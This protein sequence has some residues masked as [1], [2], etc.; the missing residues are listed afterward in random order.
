MNTSVCTRCQKGKIIKDTITNE[1]YCESCG[2]MYSNDKELGKSERQDHSVEQP[3]ALQ[4]RQQ[5]KNQKGGCTDVCE[6]YRAIKP[7]AGKGR[8][9]SGQVRCMICTI[10]IS[11]NGCLDKNGNECT[12]NTTG[13]YCKCC[14]MRVRTRPHNRK[15]KERL[16]ASE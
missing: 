1:H 4:I 7:T 11:R 6:K 16:M 13:L 10:Y 9:K 8:Y 15:Y 14:G 2:F 5:R 3:Y 12:I